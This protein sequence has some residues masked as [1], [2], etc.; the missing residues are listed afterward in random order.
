MMLNRYSLRY[1]IVMIAMAFLLTTLSYGQEMPLVK[2]K[3][4]SIG[5][6]KKHLIE[7]WGHPSK[8]D[9]K[10]KTDVWYYHNENTP[11]PTDG[12]VVNLRDGKVE[13]WKVVNN[14]YEEMRVWGKE[15]GV[16]P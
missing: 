7:N 3:G 4:I 12:I 5:L 15:A 6:K 13:D 16:S 1:Y 9:T 14:I 10:G 8:R 2:L 11:H